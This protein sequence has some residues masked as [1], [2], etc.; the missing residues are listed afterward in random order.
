MS[1]P[2]LLKG[3]SIMDRGI[4][5]L[6]TVDFG[7]FNWNAGNIFLWLSLSPA[8]RSALVSAHT[9]SP[10]PNEHP[11]GGCGPSTA[12]QRCVFRSTSS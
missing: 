7:L 5:G 9:F 3:M 12:P 8:N 2:I 11:V 4:K 6:C 1:I 10:L